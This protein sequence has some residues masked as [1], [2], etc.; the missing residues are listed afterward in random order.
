MVKA[1]GLD[2]RGAIAK[3][4]TNMARF[5]SSLIVLVVGALILADGVLG[6]VANTSLFL[7]EEPPLSKFLVGL[8]LIL[9]AAYLMPRTE[10]VD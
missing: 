7:E 3:N 4:S 6:W 9:I 1:L 8:I 2:P 5:L 10:A